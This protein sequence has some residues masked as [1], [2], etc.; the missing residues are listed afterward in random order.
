[1]D[2]DKLEC[3]VC[4]KETN[5]LY[6]RTQYNGNLELREACSDCYKKIHQEDFN[7]QLK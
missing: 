4:G 1:M 6:K 2:D 7:E 5:V 3:E